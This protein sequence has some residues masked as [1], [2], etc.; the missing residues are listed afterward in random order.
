MNKNGSR[1][2]WLLQVVLGILLI[3]LLGVHWIAQHYLAAEGLRNYAEVAAYLKQP[4]ILA[5]EI[6]FL[7]VITAHA[8]LGVRAILADLG[9]Q[10]PLQRALDATLWLIGLFTV[11]YGIQLV[12]QIV[13]Q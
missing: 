4:I 2:L 6:T 8:L 7:V 5:L 11:L 3:L 10:A 13:H 9:L 12:W 1:M